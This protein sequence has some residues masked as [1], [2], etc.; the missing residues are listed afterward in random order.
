LVIFV[1]SATRCWGTKNIGQVYGWLFTSNIPAALSPILAG[2]VFD[3]C[4]IF[5]I[6]LYILAG[7]LLAGALLIWKNASLI[8]MEKIISS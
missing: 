4:Q 7:L 2:F 3:T 5:N 8:N 6:A 1:S